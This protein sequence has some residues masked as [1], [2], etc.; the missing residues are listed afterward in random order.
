MDHSTYHYICWH[1]RRVYMTCQG[2]TGGISINPDNRL[3]NAEG[4]PF[5]LTFYDNGSVTH[6]AVSDEDAED[7]LGRIDKWYEEHPD[8]SEFPEDAPNEAFVSIGTAGRKRFPEAEL[9]KGWFEEL[10]GKSRGP[11]NDEEFYHYTNPAPAPVEGE[12]RIHTIIEQAVTAPQNPTLMIPPP[13]N[14]R[15]QILI[16]DG[17]AIMV[18]CCSGQYLKYIIPDSLIPFINAKAA[19]ML[20]KNA[21]GYH[22]E[23]DPDAWLEVQGREDKF[24]IEPDDAIRLFEEL[25]PQC[26]DPIPMVHPNGF[27]GFYTEGERKLINSAWDCPGCGAT[28][29]FGKVCGTCGPEHKPLPKAD[30]PWHCNKCKT[31]GNTGTYC[32]EC[33]SLYVRPDGL[34]DGPEDMII[35]YRDNRAALFKQKMFEGGMFFQAAAPAPAPAPAPSAQTAETAEGDLPEDSWKCTFCGHINTGKFCSEC[36]TKR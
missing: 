14:Y 13:D 6:Y 21:N 4:A 3:W 12:I 29:N 35:G 32:S 24:D 19:D 5:V 16:E 33:G 20:S 27:R 26:S 25:V 11:L 10:R 17:L 31:D 23:G 30:R 9:M 18:V 1:N 7:I 22:R 2:I 8:M 28:R 34:P 15:S 36:G